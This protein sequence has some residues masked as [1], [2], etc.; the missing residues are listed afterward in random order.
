MRRKWRLM[1]Q[2]GAS[3]KSR[4]P[5]RA[6]LGA[7]EHHAVQLQQVSVTVT[8]EAPPALFSVADWLPASAV[9]PPAVHQEQ[10]GLLHAVPAHAVPAGSSVAE[11][12][13]TMALSPPS[14]P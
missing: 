2:S 6:E 7:P 8:V 3:E 9:P 5:L 13:R 1:A 10:E 11:L 4:P 12:G 14:P